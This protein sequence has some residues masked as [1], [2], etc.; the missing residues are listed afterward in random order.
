M[1]QTTE[2]IGC[3]RSAMNR[4]LWGIGL[5]GIT[6]NFLGLDYVLPLIGVIQL[7]L[8]FRALRREHAA[9]YTGYG[10][11]WIK[12]AGCLA[13]L[14]LNATVYR[15]KVLE[16]AAGIGLV[17]LGVAAAFGVLLSLREGF[18]QAQKKLELPVHT[19]CVD[20]MIVWN[21]GSLL[22]AK[23]GYHG[24]VLGLALMIL[25]FWLLRGMYRL[26]VELENAGYEVQPL[27]KQPELPERMTDGKIAGWIL[28]VLAVGIGCGYLFLN[29]YPMEWHQMEPAGAAQAG[30]EE[31]AEDLAQIR[32]NL[33]AL[34]FPE[35]I[36]KDLRPEDVLACRGA[37]QVL[38]SEEDYPVN[39]GDEVRTQQGS[40]TQIRTEYDEKELHLTGIAVELPGDGA[41]SGVREV[42]GDEGESLKRWKLFHHFRWTKNPGFYGTEALQIWPAYRMEMGGCVEDGPFT[43]QVLYDRNGETMAADY[44]ALGS[45][46]YEQNRMLF[47]GQTATDVF[48][49]F[50]MPGQGEHHRGYVSYEMRDRESLVTVDSWV[51]YVHQSSG[52][53]YPVQTA[54]EYR[55]APGI[56]GNAFRVVQDALQFYTDSSQENGVTMLQ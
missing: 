43:G 24:L 53:Q 51:N 23:T 46:T 17:W 36:L 12:V 8:G 25:F 47:G 22:L 13:V 44:Y 28:R 42:P 32:R 26:S 49:E 21:A 7:L 39:D 56:F 29:R 4:I 40:S 41:G 34:G 35:D 31:A 20:G 1:G 14:I 55:M 18:R 33:A 3:W 5:T 16:S 15:T 54:K 30:Q 6:W 27:L 9:W 19:G 50:S 38:V 48:A 10:L 11:A 45:E 52:V 2:N 37:L